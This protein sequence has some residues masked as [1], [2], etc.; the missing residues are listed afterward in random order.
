MT[1]VGRSIQAA[2]K[3]A[4]GKIENAKKIPLVFD[5]I[6]VGSA[7][8]PRAR[9]LGYN[10]IASKGSESPITTPIIEDDK[11]SPDINRREQYGNLRTQLAFLILNRLKNSELFVAADISAALRERWQAE[12]IE[13]KY[14]VDSEG[15]YH[16]E[17]KETIK[18]RLK[19][20]PNL[21]DA[22]C[23]AFAPVRVEQ[24]VG[25]ITVAERAYN[26]RWDGVF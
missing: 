9:E 5:A 18:K 14:S 3:L 12:M 2:N 24:S 22:T 7:C 6:G 15:K 16:L 19:R 13:P 26:M 8:A 1:T 23:L 17:K 4:D 21:F 25:K 20:S 10:G 11:T